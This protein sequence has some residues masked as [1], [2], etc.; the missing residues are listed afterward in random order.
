MFKVT[1]V[2]DACGVNAVS[3]QDKG[4]RSATLAAKVVAREHGW[5]HAQY[6]GWACRACRNMPL[7]RLEPG[8]VVKYIGPILTSELVP[9][10]GH[11]ATVHFVERNGTVQAKFNDAITGHYATRLHWFFP[12]EFACPSVTP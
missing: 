4:S 7:P 9:L 11:Q 1:L 5:A 6:V 3:G 2:C 12:Q 10:C 8:Q